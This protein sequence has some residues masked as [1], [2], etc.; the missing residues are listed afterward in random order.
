MLNSSQVFSQYSESDRKFILETF[1]EVHEL[2]SID[3]S[4]MWGINLD[5]PCMIIDKNTRMILANNPDKDSL[6][7]REGNFYSGHYPE[8]KALGSSFTEYGGTV[9]ANV[10]YPFL[11]PESYLKVQLIHEIFHIVQD[12]LK[13]N[14]PQLFFRNAHMD[15]MNARIYMRLE[16]AALEKALLTNDMED[17]KEHI[18]YAL[19]FRLKRRSMFEN[20]SKEENYFEFYLESFNSRNTS[21]FFNKNQKYSC[22]QTV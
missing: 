20:V 19:K 6:L 3:N 22:P 21:L 8:N 9:F 13:L 4:Q 5:L 7:V 12:S 15:D 17:K 18:T 11:F 16:W 1:V 10:S 14:P 2:C